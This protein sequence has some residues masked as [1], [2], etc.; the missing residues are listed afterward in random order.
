LLALGIS[1]SSA[2]RLGKSNGS[3]SHREAVCRMAR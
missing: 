1:M 3:A 2:T